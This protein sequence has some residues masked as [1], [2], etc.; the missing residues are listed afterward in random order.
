MDEW[1]NGL[2]GWMYEWMDEWMDGQINILN[3]LVDVKLFVTME[4][5]YILYLLKQLIVTPVELQP[6]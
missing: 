4:V 6:V 5:F 1:M 2:N 3:L